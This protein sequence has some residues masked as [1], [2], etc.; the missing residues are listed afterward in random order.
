[1]Q[2]IKFV[3]ENGVGNQLL[4]FLLEQSHVAVIGLC[5]LAS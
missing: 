2:G 3:Q 4:L 1:M 5:S